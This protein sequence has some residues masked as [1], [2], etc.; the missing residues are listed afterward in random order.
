MG[1][2]IK[3]ILYHSPS[4]TSP[5]FKAR[6]DITAR[7]NIVMPLAEPSFGLCR[8]NIIQMVFNKYW[9]YYSAFLLKA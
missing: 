6:A 9:N 3:Q 8:I 7:N 2:V 5:S 1:I 4:F